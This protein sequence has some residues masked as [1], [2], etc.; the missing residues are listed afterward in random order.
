MELTEADFL[1]AS[2][3]GMDHS[4]QEHLTGANPPIMHRDS[5]WCAVMGD[6]DVKQYPNTAVADLR[7]AYDRG[8]SDYW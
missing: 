3:L 6:A 8:R 5:L 4:E 2:Q 1:C 7:V